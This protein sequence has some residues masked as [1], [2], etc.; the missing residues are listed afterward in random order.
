MNYMGGK[1]RQGPAI[2]K[3]IKTLLSPGC[4]YFEPFCGALGSAHRVA[5]ILPERV[6]M[7]LSDVNEPLINMWKAALDGWVP[8]DVV[9]NDEYDRVKLIRDPTDPMTAYC[10]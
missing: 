6:T 10:G 4:Y 9:T 8:P 3:V 1:H 7:H 5:Q 2:A